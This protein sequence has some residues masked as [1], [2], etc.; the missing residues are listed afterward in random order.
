MAAVA[1]NR[2]PRWSHRCGRTSKTRS[3][4]LD[5]A[6]IG[7]WRNRSVSRGSDSPKPEEVPPATRIRGITEPHIRWYFP[8]GTGEARPAVLIFPGGAYNYVVVDKEGSEVAEWFNQQGIAAGVVLYRTKR[9]TAG[10]S[11]EQAKVTAKEPAP[12]DPALPPDSS[13]PWQDAQRSVRWTRAHAET[14]RI[15]PTKIGVVGFSAGGLTAA[16]AATR[17]QIPAVPPTD[18]TDSVSARPDFCML[19]YPWRLASDTTGEL[20]AALPIGAAT[21]PT[22]L[23]HTH[24]DRTTSLSSVAFY[25]ALVSQKIPAE[26]HIFQTGGHGYGIRPVEN[27]EVDTW[28][29]LA[30]IWLRGRKLIP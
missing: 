17:F 22:F 2:N 5:L 27:S 28:P 1:R 12:T 24:D 20:S 30:E 15:D 7:A 18:E 26:L 4:R 6:R 10:G 3:G 29:A 21:P 9:V 13:R 25:R 14:L 23:V 8:A 11:G 19:F 16:L